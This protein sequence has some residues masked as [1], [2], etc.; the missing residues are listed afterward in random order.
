ME[1]I[2]PMLSVYQLNDPYR[3]PPIEDL[4]DGRPQ[5]WTGLELSWTTETAPEPVYI[6]PFWL[7][8][9][10]DEEREVFVFGAAHDLKEALIDGEIRDWGSFMEFSAVAKDEGRWRLHRLIQRTGVSFSATDEFPDC[11]FLN[12]MEKSQ[13]S[14]LRRPPRWQTRSSTEWPLSDGKPMTF[15]GQVSLP[16][17]EVTK[18]HLTWG[19]TLY[20][21]WCPETDAFKIMEQKTGAQDIEDHYA[22]EERR[23]VGP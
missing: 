5:S 15:V 11:T 21:F 17:N 8:A 13:Q 1:R 22:D 6:A 23:G 7:P 18:E 19:S 12:D 10:A 16:E 14:W 20:L 2:A 3:L 9:E 4:V